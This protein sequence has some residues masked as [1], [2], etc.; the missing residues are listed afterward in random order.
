MSYQERIYRQAGFCVEKNNTAQ[1]AKFSS[2]IYIILNY[3]SL[4]T[5]F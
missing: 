1:I 3:K 4:N 2:D 5:Y